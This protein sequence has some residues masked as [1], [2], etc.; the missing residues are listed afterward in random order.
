MAKTL[1]NGVND[2]LIKAKLIQGDS[3]SLTT[4]TDSP[5]QVWIDSAKQAWNE[6]VEELYSATG[7]PM[8]QELAENTITLVT[9]TRAYTLQSDLVILHWPFIDETNGQ[10][11]YE[12]EG[13][14]LDLVSIQPVPSDYTGLP[15]YGAIRPTD[16]YLYLD[17]IPSSTENGLVYK[18]RYDKDVSLS[19]A[20]DTFP[21]GNSVYRALVEAAHEKFNIHTRREFISG[22]Y[23]AAM[24]RAARLLTQKPQRTSYL[25]VGTVTESGIENPFE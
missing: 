2:L 10:Y 9:N 13:G 14:Y 6:V 20:T 5:R 18:Y 15:L 24:G 25:S 8:P 3:G 19:L 16:S 11:I 1:L 23:D 12:Y 4:L 17:R 22:V 21:F 7:K